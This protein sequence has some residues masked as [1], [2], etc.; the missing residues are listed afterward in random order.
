MPNAEF[1]LRVEAMAENEVLSEVEQR[2]V[3]A[4]QAD[5]RAT[6]RK[7]AKVIGEPERT[8]ARYGTALLDEGKIKDAAIAHRKA[9]VIASLK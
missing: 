1:G 8:V 2:I 9:A 6:W 3:I 4:L 5:G 7:I